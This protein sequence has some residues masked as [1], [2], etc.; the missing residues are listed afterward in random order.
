MHRLLLRNLD[1]MSNDQLDEVFATIFNI[2]PLPYSNGSH[3]DYLL[4]FTL[5]AAIKVELDVTKSKKEGLIEV[6]LSPRTTKV[7]FA[8]FRDLYYQGLQVD[9]GNKKDKI[10]F[11]KLD[12][13]RK[14]IGVAPTLMKALLELAYRDAFAAL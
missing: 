6:T 10:Y 9:L 13:A 11:T 1:A 7:R 8:E 2:D 3:T 12:I 4:N 5:D 14:G